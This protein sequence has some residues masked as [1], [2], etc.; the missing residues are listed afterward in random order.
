MYAAVEGAF[1][2]ALLALVLMVGTH[3]LAEVLARKQRRP[4]P[5]RDER[6]LEFWRDLQE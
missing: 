4:L 2:W 6:H 5:E 3:W 1:F